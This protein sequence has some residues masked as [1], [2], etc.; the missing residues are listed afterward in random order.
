MHDPGGGIE[1]GGL[2]VEAQVDP[3]PLPEVPRR[4]G[5]EVLGPFHQA[6]QVI[7]DAAH[8]VGGVAG[9]LQDDDLQVRVHP[10]GGGGGRH[11]RRPASDDDQSIVHSHSFVDPGRYE[12]GPAPSMPVRGQ[13]APRHGPPGAANPDG[14][15][16]YREP[17][18]RE[19]SPDVGTP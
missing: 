14:L 3:P 18:P 6:G 8:P 16:P 12:A 19:E 17:R 2:G 11:A 13:R 1:A 7:G 4:V 5:Q 9:G 10:A 15:Y